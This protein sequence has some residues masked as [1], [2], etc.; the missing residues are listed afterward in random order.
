MYSCLFTTTHFKAERHFRAIFCPCHVP[1][2]I[3]SIFM[4][5][6][7]TL[8][9]S[10]PAWKY[11]R[12]LFLIFLKKNGPCYVANLFKPELHQIIILG[13][14]LNLVQTAIN[15]RFFHGS[16]ISFIFNQ[17]PSVVKNEPNASSFQRLKK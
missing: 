13:S 6:A 7:H 12:V 16:A 17:L 9:I 10:F 15:S 14:G 4:A 8:L 1:V 5:F 2:R 11:P 3:G